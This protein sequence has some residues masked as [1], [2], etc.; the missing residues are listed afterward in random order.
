[1]TNQH[2]P[3]LV[4]VVIPC[5]NA[6][7]WI[8][9][10][11]QSCLDQTYREIEIIVVDDGSTDG[12][13]DV[14]KTFGDKIRVETGPN[15]GGNRARNRGFRSSHGE[16]I[17]FLDADDYLLSEKI[18]RQA[19][20]LSTTGADV[21]YGDWRH[22]H[23][24]DNGEEIFEDIKISGVQP[25]VLQSL[26]K[27]WWVSPAC[28][29]FRR[30][31]V[32]KAGGWDESLQAAQDKDFFISVVMTKA[33][34]RYQAGCD[35]IYRRY[36]NVTVS[37]S[38]LKRWLDSHRE[39]LEKAE[40]KLEDFGLLSEDYRHALAQSYFALARSYYD[41]N[42]D[43]YRKLLKK[44]LE[45]NPHFKPVESQSY[46]LIQKI[47]GFEMAERMAGLKRQLKSR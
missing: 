34:V 23:H 22:K 41:I 36:G 33:D 1:M 40:T 19:T 20:F 5:Y 15:Q 45:L 43:S 12:S 29:L 35:S 6:E 2:P 37:T 27:G 47:G 26:L 46:N 25:D 38:N 14:L 24:L 13:L 17:Q 21:V 7:R 8:A 3:A 30:G 4:S 9:E 18:E 11:V 32:E 10:A 39:V 42:R 44:T 31:T 28:L 16:Y